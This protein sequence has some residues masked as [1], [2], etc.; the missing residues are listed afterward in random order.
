[1]EVV[2]KV[3]AESE[4][5]MDK[6]GKQWSKWVQNLQWQWVKMGRGSQSGWGI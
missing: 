3:G 2:V 5:A 1:M 4:V 6:N